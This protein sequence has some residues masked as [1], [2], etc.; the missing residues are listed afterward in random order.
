LTAPAADASGGQRPSA[1]PSGAP[2]GPGNPTSDASAAPPATDPVAPPGSAPPPNADAGADAPAQAPCN[3]HPALCGRRFDQVVFPA[4]HNAMSNADDRWFIPDQTHNMRRQLADGIRALLIDT[5]LFNGGSFLCHTSCA[6]GNRPLVDGLKDVAEFLRDNPREV[7]ALLV[8]DYLSA[9]ETEKA[10]I[11]SG[12]EPF[13]YTHPSGQPWPT[14][15]EMIDRG[16]RLLVLS[17]NSHPPPAWYHGMW[18]LVWDTPY[19]FK[20]ET[21]FSCR[22]NRGKRSNDLFLLNHWLE[23]PVPDPRLSAIANAR[24][25][26]LARARQCQQESGKLPNFVA[27]SHYSLGALFE[28]VRTLNGLDPTP[29]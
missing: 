11:A 5:Y 1:D 21:E 12:L 22:E 29:P 20:N 14:L 26:L 18:D 13:L 16:Q 2:A 24:D 8:E 15:G 19:A 25:L 6:F 27:V 7:L 10:F 3:G 23:N 17:Q 4:A 28:V 9:A